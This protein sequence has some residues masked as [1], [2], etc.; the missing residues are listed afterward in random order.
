MRIPRGY[1]TPRVLVAVGPRALPRL[2]A[3]LAGWDATYIAELR[4]LSRLRTVARFHLVIIGTHF[5]AS[6]GIDTL[7]EVLRKRPGCPV[8][9]VRASAFEA[10]LGAASF[11]AYSSACLELGADDVLELLRY[12]DDEAGNARVRALLV[13]V[14]RP[15]RR[16]SVI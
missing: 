16:A 6:R 5:D 2:R 8:V 4:D 1:E 7:V 13:R 14:M 15:A 10:R 11:Y 3:I 12:P 9:C